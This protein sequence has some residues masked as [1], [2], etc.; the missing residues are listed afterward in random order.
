VLTVVFNNARWGA[1]DNAANSL[2]PEGHWRSGG[3]PS[4]SDL[5]P[6]PALERYA[7]ASGGYGE[8]VSKRDELVPALRR[9]LHAVEVERR[10]A[11]LNIVGE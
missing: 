4:L 1:V 10:Q 2:F 9:A 5:A 11:L 3:G 6:M 7:E 8:R